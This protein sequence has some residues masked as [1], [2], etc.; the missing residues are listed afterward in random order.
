[1]IVR[2]SAVPHVL[3]EI[4]DPKSHAAVRRA[5][6]DSDD[7]VRIVAAEK[8][9]AI[10]DRSWFRIVPPALKSPDPGGEEEE[11][12]PWAASSASREFVPSLLA[13]LRDDNRT[14]QDCRARIPEEDRS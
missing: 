11:Q 10:G 6:S 4:G 9:A 3:A 8:L 1:M 5:L 7:L 12:R 14:S 2:T 13:A